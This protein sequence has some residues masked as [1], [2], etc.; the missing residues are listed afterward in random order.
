MDGAM[1]DMCIGECDPRVISL[2]WKQ[3]ISGEQRKVTIPAEAYEPD[4]LPRGAPAGEP[5]HYFVELKSIFRPVP[6]DRW[7]DDDGLNIEV[8]LSIAVVNVRMPCLGDAQ[9]R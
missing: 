5:L 4:E 9:D 1:R 3:R 8:A 6:G 2:Q 7:V